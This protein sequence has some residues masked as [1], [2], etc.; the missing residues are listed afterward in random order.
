MYVCRYVCMRPTPWLINHSNDATHDALTHSSSGGLSSLEQSNGAASA[1]VNTLFSASSGSIVAWTIGIVH[2]K[3]IHLPNACNGLLAGLVAITGPCAYVEPW[4]AILIG[5]CAA[6]VVMSTIHAMSNILHI[7][8]PLDAFAI[9][10][11]CGALGVVA[12]G[13]FA[14]D[15]GLV[16][17][18][19]PDLLI[20]QFIGL[21]VIIAWSGVTCLICFLILRYSVGIAVDEDDQILG[22]DLLY[23]SG[24][25][26]PEF[27]TTSVVEFNRHKQLKRSRLKDDH[28]RLSFTNSETGGMGSEGLPAIN[29][30][31]HSKRP[32]SEDFSSS[33]GYGRWSEA[34]GIAASERSLRLEK[35]F[36]VENPSPSGY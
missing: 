7:D 5:V 36:E 32:G 23:G 27:D 12:T 31:R 35:N 8:D 11:A 28:D 22:L 24:F 17:S 19:S 1:A 15:G 34:R 25:A 6:V 4:A 20:A 33:E 26:Y 9:H 3:K 2:M 29:Y 16:M 21:A 30:R 18:G 14:I 13:V 10:G